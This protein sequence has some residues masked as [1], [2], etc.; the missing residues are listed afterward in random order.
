MDKKPDLRKQLRHGDIK[1]LMEVTG[2]S[3]DLIQKVLKGDRT[4][5]EVLSAAKI[6]ADARKEKRQQMEKELKKRVH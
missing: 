5:E 2:Y 6:I 3:R 4:N 1:T